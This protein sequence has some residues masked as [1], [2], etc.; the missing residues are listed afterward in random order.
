LIQSNDSSAFAVEAV[1]LVTLIW[2]TNSIVCLTL[3]I[4]TT[5]SFANWLT[6]TIAAFANFAS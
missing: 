5:V 1:T 6:F 4:N 3:A 2:F